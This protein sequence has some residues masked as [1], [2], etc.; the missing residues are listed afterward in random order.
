MR[1]F[2]HPPVS[3]NRK[4][5]AMAPQTNSFV[6]IAQ[7]APAKVSAKKRVQDYHEII[8]PLSAK[9]AADQ[10][11]RCA[12]CGVPFCQSACPLHN[13]IPDWLAMMAE[14]KEKEA[15]ELSAQTST[16]PEICGRICPKI[17]SVKGFVC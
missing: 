14:G 6:S 11:S 9:Q 12:Q 15:W 7:A 1:Q 4:N 10:S 13:N 16:M 3:S 17:A 8:Q 5:A 2:T